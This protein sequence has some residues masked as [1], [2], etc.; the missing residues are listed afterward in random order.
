MSLL[1]R[2]Q[3]K[4]L[5]CYYCNQQTGRASSAARIEAWTC[6][7][8][9]ALNVLDSQ[10]NI[11]DTIPEKYQRHTTRP[12]AH[13]PKQ[14]PD[15]QSPFCATC[16]SNQA[17]LTKTLASYLPDESDKDYALYESA[18][19][20]Y[21][22]SLE[23]RFPPFCASCAPALQ[24]R[25]E[26]NNYVAKSIA[27]GGWLSG[28]IDQQSH[29]S[30][31]G[32]ATWLVRGI[33]FWTVHAAVLIWCLCEAVS[34]PIQSDLS[35]PMI[36]VCLCLGAF[37]NP[38]AIAHQQFPRLKVHGKSEYLQ[39]QLS[40]FVLRF[41]AF[42]ILP[43]L[44]VVSPLRTRF[45]M[46]GVVLSLLH[47]WLST[48]LVWLERPTVARLTDT[49]T[50][51]RDMLPAEPDFDLAAPIRE[52]PFQVPVARHQSSKEYIE[53]AADDD[54]EED[55]M[56]WQPSPPASRAS[57]F[58][59][60]FAPASEAHSVF[61]TSAF[62]RRLP[63]E[64]S[65]KSR[66]TTLLAP[67]RLFAPEQPTGLE[68]LFHAAVRLE[69]EPLLV[70]SLRQVRRSPLPLLM[71]VT[72]LAALG[73]SVCLVLRWYMRC[74]LLYGVSGLGLVHRARCQMEPD[75]GGRRGRTRRTTMT[76]HK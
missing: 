51:L 27:L 16:S 71:V 70:R 56:D 7:L 34:R 54:E 18:L 5:T 62:T 39:L 55:S 75:D 45:G 14:A 48:Q 60:T 52:S 50:K 68:S 43:R 32:H 61:G 2:K 25:L 67:Q 20:A 23:E 73:G 66:D 59:S 21:K 26:R 65:E 35:W 12:L 53:V 9:E 33:C 28:R 41:A 40:M 37:W 10:G 58:A 24:A 17:L 1:K 29:V 42:I 69:D 3:T 76:W 11:A 4:L 63:T 31:L 64:T 44:A 38:Q 30:W 72:S 49:S 47:A 15:L 74:L 22:A 57:P 8:C 46:L 19:P 6:P 13:R 36:M